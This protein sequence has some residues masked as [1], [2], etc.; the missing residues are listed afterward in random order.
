MRVDDE[1]GEFEVE[2]TN[3]ITEEKIG[4]RYVKGKDVRTK[5]AFG[6]DVRTKNFYEDVRTKNVL[7]KD[8]QMK[9]VMNGDVKTVKRSMMSVIKRVIMMATECDECN[10]EFTTMPTV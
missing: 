8:V 9:N 2:T 1:C 4:R 3:V 10:K 7:G 5:K 6:K